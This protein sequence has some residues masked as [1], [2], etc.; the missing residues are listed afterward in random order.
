MSHIYLI[1]AIV[2]IIVISLALWGIMKK[3]VKDEII[4]NNDFIKK[5]RNIAKDD[6]HILH[7]LRESGCD[8]KQLLLEFPKTHE[9]SKKYL[10]KVNKAKDEFIHL[11]DMPCI[12]FMD[13]DEIIDLYTWCKDHGKKDCSICYKKDKPLDNQLPWSPQENL[14][15]GAANLFDHTYF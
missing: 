10:K 5:F 8:E 14:D 2:A 4:E 12:G 15:P 1:V 11:L 9:E 13:A 6:P 3:S 7:V